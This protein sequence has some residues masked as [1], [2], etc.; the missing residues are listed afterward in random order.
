MKTEY[1]QSKSRNINPQFNPTPPLLK[2]DF[3]N[4][5][6]TLT[7]YGFVGMTANGYGDS[8]EMSKVTL[9]KNV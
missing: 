6:V 4:E 5:D 9:P 3:E 2:V 8:V 7:V 1:Y